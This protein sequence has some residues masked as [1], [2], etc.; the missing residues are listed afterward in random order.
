[1]H[2]FSCFDWNE[3]T[4]EIIYHDS[5][6]EKKNLILPYDTNTEDYDHSYL[7]DKLSSFNKKKKDLSSIYKAFP[8]ISFDTDKTSKFYPLSYQSLIDLTE[9]SKITH[10][11]RITFGN[12]FLA[13]YI[14]SPEILEKF[15]NYNT[16][17]QKCFLLIKGEDNN[18]GEFTVIPTE[19]ATFL[20][21]IDEEVENSFRFNNKSIVFQNHLTI[22]YNNF[23]NIF[24]IFSEKDHESYYH[25]I[26]KEIVHNEYYTSF[27]LYTNNKDNIQIDAPQYENYYKSLI[28]TAPPNSSERGGRRCVFKSLTLYNM[29]LEFVRT[30]I[31]PNYFVNKVF[32]INNY[33]P[34]EHFDEHYDTMFI[35]YKEKKFS[36][37]T[38]LLYFDTKDAELSFPC[39]QKLTINKDMIVI[40]PHWVKHSAIGTGSRNVIKTEIGLKNSYFEESTKLSNQFNIGTYFMLNSIVFPELKK[41]STEYFNLVNES[42]FL[43]EELISSIKRT[44]FIH[45]FVNIVVG[46]E[47]K[48]ITNN[49]KSLDFSEYFANFITNGNDVFFRIKNFKD[50]MINFIIK[51]IIHDILHFGSLT[52]HKY[53]CSDAFSEQMH[54]FR[55]KHKKDE[56]FLFENQITKLYQDQTLQD[57]LK[58]L[59]YNDDFPLNYKCKNTDISFNFASCYSYLAIYHYENKINLPNFK[60]SY[61]K[62]QELLQIDYSVFH[63]GI[64]IEK[65]YIETTYSYDE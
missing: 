19:N 22:K 8:I 13:K 14:C 62:E 6:L 36:T 47:K 44:T 16:I 26:P 65:K 1:M 30:Y 24:D 21:F 40:I 11:N 27:V 64:R 33:G 63:S 37:H 52:E 45:K 5:V 9:T 31:G 35:N 58:N 12:L 15:Q 25:C 17:I 7:K 10:F 51:I 4:N 54:E 55:I 41:I 57:T 48:E 50:E 61:D 53:S 34:K 28:L 3:K 49:R 56:T 39:D 43:P 20:K 18:S 42:R 29:I 32:K 38:L 59:Q 46:E 23:E 2:Y 60:Y